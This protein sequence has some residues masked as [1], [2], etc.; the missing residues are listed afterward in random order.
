MTA[1]WLIAFIALVAGEAAT[2][3]LVCIWF[4]AGAAGGFVTAVLG[5]PFWLQ[6]VVFAAVSA[7]TLA[8]VRPAA[9]RFAHPRRSPTNADRVIGQVASVTET[10]DNEAAAGQV[11][12]LGQIWTARSQLGVVIPKGSQ[13]I[14]KRIEGVKVFV[15]TV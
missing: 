10:I 11:S 15:E 6:L 3:G 13:V 12:V 1:F 9:S 8:L 2:V 14:V 7:L 5:G 4:A